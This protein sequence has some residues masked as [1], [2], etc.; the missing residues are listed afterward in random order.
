MKRE[1]LL[2]EWLQ[3]SGLESIPSPT[4][5]LLQG[6]IASLS[7]ERAI[8]MEQDPASPLVE[9]YEAEIAEMENLI[10]TNGVDDSPGAH[11]R[12]EDFWNGF[13]NYFSSKVRIPDPAPQ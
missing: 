11:Q 10:A 4:T 12:Y 7:N 8:I 13:S 6:R 1:E 5:P 2:A 3:L 9:K